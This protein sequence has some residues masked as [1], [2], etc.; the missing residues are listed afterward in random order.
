MKTVGV[1][2]RRRVTRYFQRLALEGGVDARAAWA[3]LNSQRKF[4]AFHVSTAVTRRRAAPRPVTTSLRV[5]R[6]RRAPGR[7][8]IRIR[9]SSRTRARAPASDS[10]SSSSDP[11]TPSPLNSCVEHA[12]V[13]SLDQG[14][15][16]FPWLGLLLVH[17][18]ESVG[19]AGN[20]PHQVP[21]FT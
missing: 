9:G 18:S 16:A 1:R 4:N 11:P 6:A 17:T 21:R 19:A 3:H 7:R 12:A 13:K 20:C 5:L 10:G 14:E 15:P 8:P 2:S